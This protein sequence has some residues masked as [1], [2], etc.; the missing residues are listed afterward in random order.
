MLLLL[1]LLS[2]E[3]VLPNLGLLG[4][5]DSVLVPHSVKGKERRGVFDA[6]AFNLGDLFLRR[7]YGSAALYNSRP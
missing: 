5:S 3:L 4:W 1:T 6:K 2:A 7:S